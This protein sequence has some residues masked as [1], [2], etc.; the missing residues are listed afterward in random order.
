VRQVGEAATLI[1]IVP[2]SWEDDLRGHAD[3]LRQETAK[4]NRQLLRGLATANVQLVWIT[5]RTILPNV[6]DDPRLPE[7][8]IPLPAPANATALLKTID[9]QAYAGA[10][11]ALAENLDEDAQPSPLARR[12]AVG[13]VGLGGPAPR[14]AKAP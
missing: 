13:V 2:R 11:E 10:A 8:P 9:W 3:A 14:A 7:R 12:L 1:I 4:R 6:L 5:S